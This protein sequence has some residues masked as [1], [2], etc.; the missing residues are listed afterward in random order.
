MAIHNLLPENLGI[1]ESISTKDHRLAIAVD[2]ANQYRRAAPTVSTDYDLDFKKLLPAGQ[3]CDLKHFKSLPEKDKVKY[4]ALAFEVLNSASGAD[5]KTSVLEK[6]LLA[7]LSHKTA[8]GELALITSDRRGSQ[9]LL[10]N[11]HALASSESKSGAIPTLVDRRWEVLA[12]LIMDITGTIDQGKTSFCVPTSILE[13]SYLREP[14]EIARQVKEMV[15][16]GEIETNLPDKTGSYIKIKANSLGFNAQI[17]QGASLSSMLLAC[18]YTAYTGI[19]E[20]GMTRAQ[21]EDFLELFA[22][23]A[24]LKALSKDRS[25]HEISAPERVSLAAPLVAARIADTNDN[26]EM[27]HFFVS[28]Q[29]L[30]SDTKGNSENAASQAHSYHNLAVVNYDKQTE[31]FTALNPWPDGYSLPK[32]LVEDFGLKKLDGAPGS[33]GYISIPKASM[34]KL[35][36]WVAFSSSDLNNI[37]LSSDALGSATETTLSADFDFLLFKKL[38]DER[39]KAA[40][41]K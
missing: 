28:M 19:T 18:S 6:N 9:N 41:N 1:V 3:A 13:S 17:A 11:L 38:L 4:L 21:S 39:H 36:N 23:P 37:G 30:I 8:N 26:G 14:A 25:A 12:N 10:D 20:T 40:A 24:Q 33:S 22:G 2:I 32:R 15:L 7:L 16:E 27:K 34:E 35:M 5:F 31:R 29:W